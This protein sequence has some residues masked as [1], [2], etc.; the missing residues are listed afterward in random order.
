M[1][2]QYNSSYIKRQQ[3]NASI[4]FAL[5]I[6]G[7]FSLFTLGVEGGRYLRTESRL[8]D[9]A[10]IA[11]LVMTATN[12]EDQ[13][14]NEAAV[15]DI[16]AAYM[17]DDIGVQSNVIRNECEDGECGINVSSNGGFISYQVTATSRHN[18]WFPKTADIA[19]FDAQVDISASATALKLNSGKAD[20]VFAFNIGQ[21]ILVDGVMNNSDEFQQ[22]KDIIK[23]FSAMVQTANEAEAEIANHQQIAVVPFNE[24]TRDEE[25]ALTEESG[26]NRICDREEL[27]LLP[28]NVFD[29]SGPGKVGYY[30]NSVDYATTIDRLLET[31]NKKYCYDDNS[32]SSRRFFTIALTSTPQADGLSGKLDNFEPGSHETAPYEGLIRA[33]Q[34]ISEATL[35]RRYII[36]LTDGRRG[37]EEIFIKL[38]ED[39]N[40]CDN[41]RS[42]VNHLTT[43][44]G[45]SVDLKIILLKVGDEALFDGENYS[46]SHLVRYYSQCVDSEIFMTETV[47]NDAP[48]P[49]KELY[50]RLMREEIGHVVTQE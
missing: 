50:Q 9:A 27:I 36:M 41:I 17:P 20:V 49:G 33:A 19:G 43:S 1:K 37:Y 4:L 12:N 21:N 38:I 32:L 26:Y 16:I 35:A 40:L 42:Q 39:Y 8:N 22:A 6:L 45:S 5:V 46:E 25:D 3:G 23:Q 11:S 31:E 10:E 15:R 44:D 47:M 2:I 14:E 24:R 28:G 13:D 30:V 7:L 34:I 29:H 18:S 48:M